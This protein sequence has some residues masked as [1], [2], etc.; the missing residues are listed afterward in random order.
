M[1]LLSKKR[2]GVAEL[3]KIPGAPCRVHS[4]K[5]L[6]E[7]GLIIRNPRI[8]HHHFQKAMNQINQRL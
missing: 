2:N 3:V 4:I 8:F 1:P 6:H 5:S 7:S